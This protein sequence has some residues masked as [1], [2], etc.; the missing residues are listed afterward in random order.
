LLKFHVDFVTPAN[1]TFNDG[2][3]GAFG[4]FIALPIPGTVR[5]CNG[6]GAACIPQPGT[7]QQLDTLGDR[8]M[9]RL[10]YR[11]RGGVDTLVNTQSIDP[12]GVG[13]IQSALRVYEIRNALAAAP[14]L[15]QNFNYVPDSTNR[16]MGSA[17]MDKA[18]N[19]AIGYSVSD[20]TTN[21]GIRMT[22]RLR[23]E[24]RNRMQIESVIVNGSGSQLTTLNRWGDYSAMQVDPADDCTFWY[25]T[26]YIGANGTFNWR[27]RIASFKFPGCQ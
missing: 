18:G 10:V 16:W 15:F 23:S 24:L 13:P 5:A 11:N 27:T 3:G 20:S 26:E 21:P 19:M 9:Y 22:G 12:D 4:S 8:I 17:A 6:T 25:T 7:T 14:T 1:S 2:F